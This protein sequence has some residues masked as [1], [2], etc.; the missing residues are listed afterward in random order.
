MNE[1]REKLA[2]SEYKLCA[3]CTELKIK[4]EHLKN[5]EAKE[6]WYHK[7]DLFLETETETHRIAVVKKGESPELSDEY[8]KEVSNGSH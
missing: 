4:W 5:P 8:Y 3:C 2:E 6:P 1:M 7:A